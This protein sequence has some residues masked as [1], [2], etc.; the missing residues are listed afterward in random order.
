LRSKSSAVMQPN[1]LIRS[2]SY[3]SFTVI[4]SAKSS[5]QTPMHIVQPP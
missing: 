3:G 4:A 5:M 2:R 1:C